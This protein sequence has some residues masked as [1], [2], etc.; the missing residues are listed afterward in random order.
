MGIGPANPLSQITANLNVD[1]STGWQMLDGCVR[2]LKLTS[3]APEFA[4]SPNLAAVLEDAIHT[5]STLISHHRKTTSVDG[6][7]PM[8]ASPLSAPLPED[9]GT[10][11]DSSNPSADA[12]TLPNP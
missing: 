6:D 10:E 9:D 12:G 11:M 3:L 5:F 2:M 1:L 4:E 7:A 8:S